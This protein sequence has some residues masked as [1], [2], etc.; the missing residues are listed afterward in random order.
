MKVLVLTISDRA[1]GNIYEDVSGKE[2][3]QRLQAHFP[4]VHITREIVPDEIEMIQAMFQQYSEYDFILTTGGTGLS[5]RDVT[6]EATEA[7]CDRL[8]PGIAEILR[9]E[10]YKQTPN[11]MLSRAVAGIKEKT[12]IVN[13]PGSV[14]GATFCT[15]LLVPILSHA[16]KM[17]RGEGH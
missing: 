17:M 9:N 6:P 1:F 2:I 5:E 8:V 11:A 3:E 16:T 4:E 10:S 13:L 7:F 15:E 14:K 12:L